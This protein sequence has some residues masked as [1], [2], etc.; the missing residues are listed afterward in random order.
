MMAVWREGTAPAFTQADL[1]FLVGL[2]QQATIAIDNA[3]L[4]AEA[5]TARK[6][7]DEANQAKSAF[8]AAMSHEIRTPM[9]AIIGMSGLLLETKLDEEQRDFA[10]TIRTS[11][12]ALLTIINDILDF[13]KIEAGKVD[14]VHEPFAL[15]SSVE[16]A[17]DLIA[18]T[19]AKKGIE[20]AYEVTGDLPAAVAGDQGRL[21]QIVLNLLSNAIKFTSSGE[22]V[23]S[24]RAATIRKRWEV[25]IDVRDTG[26]GVPANQLGRLFQSFSQADSTISRR[27][28]GSRSAVASPRPWTEASWPRALASR[29]R[30][31]PSTSSWWWMQPTRQPCP[32]VATAT[33]S[34]SP[35]GAP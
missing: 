4:F 19:A 21:R 24:I 35:A 20:L 1:D 23:V 13:S 33:S 3:R 18:P 6:A 17:L 31:P 25:S 7:A 16:G 32:S 30:G 14:L 22:V 34:T 2:S 26:I 10:D 12:D 28:G 29:A 8:L 11:G 15:S 5:D 9:N 27:F